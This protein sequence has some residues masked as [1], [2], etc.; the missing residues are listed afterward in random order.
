MNPDQRLPALFSFVLFVATATLGW[1]SLG[2]GSGSQ[3]AEPRSSAQVPADY[4]YVVARLWED[5][6]QA[7]QMEAA[8]D[9]DGKTIGGLTLAQIQDSI[10]ETLKTQQVCLLVVP[11]PETPFPVDVESRLRMRYS[12]QMALADQNY[13]PKNRNYLGYIRWSAPNAKS[14]PNNA[15]APT[16]DP[17][18]SPSESR[19]TALQGAPPPAHIPYEWFTPRIESDAKSKPPTILLLWLPENHLNRQPL[20]RICQLREELLGRSKSD[21][22]GIFLVG[23]RSSES[24]LAL[25]RGTK[26]ADLQKLKGKLSIFSPQATAPDELIGVK[27]GKTPREGLDQMMRWA[28]ERPDSPASGNWKYFHNYIPTDDQL[29]DLLASELA[30]RDVDLS[31]KD[32]K[33]EI[34]ILAEADTSYGR[35]LPLALTNSIRKLRAPQTA[36]KPKVTEAYFS[37]EEDPKTGETAGQIDSQLVIYRYLRGLDQQKG[38]AAAEKATNRPAAKSPEELLADVLSKEGAP[39]VGESQLDYVD[40][41]AA[42]LDRIDQRNRAKRIR[43]VGV[44]GGDVYDKLILLRSLRQKYPEAVF[45]TTDLDARLTHPN[46]LSFT[47]NLIVASGYHLQAPMKGEATVDTSARIPPFRDVY[48][49]SVFEACRAAL[50]KAA[51][52][53]GNCDDDPKPSIVEIGRNGYVPLT[54]TKT[55]PT[56][57]STFVGAARNVGWFDLIKH[58]GSGIGIFVLGIVLGMIAVRRWFAKA[59]GLLS[60][61]R[62]DQ[63]HIGCVVIVLALLLVWAY[64]AM[65]YIAWQP[66]SEPWVGHQGVSI[67]PT[68]MIRLFVIVGVVLITIWSLNRNDRL[69]SS[70]E[71]TYFSGEKLRPRLPGDDTNPTRVAKEAY[72]EYLYRALWKRR[73]GR[74]TLLT[75]AYMC[76]AFGLMF[77]LE[78]EFPFRGHIRGPAAQSVDKIVLMVAIA[79]FL[80]LLFYVLDAAR[81][82]SR[83]LLTISHKETIWP[84]EI[85][86]AQRQAFGVSDRDLAGY[87]DVQFAAEKSQEVGRLIIF[88]FVVQLVFIVSRSTYF[89]HWTWPGSLLAIFASNFLLAWTAWTILRR[90]ARKIRNDAEHTI[91]KEID[92]IHLGTKA[93]DPVGEVAQAGS[94]RQRLRRLEFLKKRVENEQRGAYSR[95]FQDPAV[96]ATILPTG[97]FG[98]LAVLLRAFF[99]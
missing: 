69:E 14:A 68:E 75:V 45:F 62:S 15:A 44:L 83:L 41:V 2:P 50:Q 32:S 28:I 5:P 58:H 39:A 59:A 71:E 8:K 18:A 40:R 17:Q 74:I 38:Q 56:L 55:A 33:D 92:A 42:D 86:K 54:P 95:L 84:A 57:G 43:A 29:T 98:I 31:G 22:S 96:I 73:F 65:Q 77:I 97:I 4:Q 66:G 72:Q 24:L 94:P 46:H 85:L 63:R 60:C 27:S 23:P 88:P 82:T 89:D 12:V 11:I 78:G 1:L 76:F 19:Q 81:I 37:D 26:P 30:L 99:V 67:W 6:L 16:G 48:Q 70:I 53:D 49:V 80:W 25:A 52:N 9:K 10:A 36:P 21:F 90:C 93:N 64:S 51:G 13:A 61:F 7:I 20:D 34:L 35:L 3:L 47:R 79:A 87:L 91:Q